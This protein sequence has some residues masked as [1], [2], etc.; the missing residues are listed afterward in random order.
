MPIKFSVKLKCGKCVVQ[1]DAERAPQLV[2]LVKWSG[3][4]QLHYTTV[5]RPLSSRTNRF[6]VRRNIIWTLL[7]FVTRP[8]RRFSCTRR[9]AMRCT[10]KLTRWLGENCWNATRNRFCSCV[11]FP[12]IFRYFGLLDPDC[13]RKSQPFA[14]FENILF[15]PRRHG[16][17]DAVKNTTPNRIVRIH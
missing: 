14:H 3:I 9:D 7:Q 6:V 2:R 8:K 13:T 11:W 16:L 12:H 4:F 5:S 1:L 17:L 10:T 15:N